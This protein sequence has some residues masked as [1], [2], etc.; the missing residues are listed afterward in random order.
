MT[1]DFSPTGYCVEC[2]LPLH[3]RWLKCESSTD[4]SPEAIAELRRTIADCERTQNDRP[5]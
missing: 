3:C 1:H 5:M 2:G 4:D